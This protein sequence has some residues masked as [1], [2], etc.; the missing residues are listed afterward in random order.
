MYPL[1][2]FNKILLPIKKKN[3]QIHF[4]SLQICYLSP[5][6]IHQIY[7]ILGIALESHYFIIIIKCIWN[8]VI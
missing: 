3:L 7:N 8:F 4:L 6:F 5:T 2:S 1:L